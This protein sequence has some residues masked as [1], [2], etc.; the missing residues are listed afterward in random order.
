LVEYPK[1][2]E[3][4]PLITDLRAGGHNDDFLLSDVG[5]LYLRPDDQEPTGAALLVP[6]NG[7]IRAEV[8]EDAHINEEGE[9]KAFLGMTSQLGEV[10][11]WVGMEE[12]IERQIKQCEGCSGVGRGGEKAETDFEEGYT[13][14]T[15]WTGV[16]EDEKK[17]GA[18]AADMAMAMRR[19]EEDAKKRWEA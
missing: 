13:G 15:G 2:P 10:F 19:A 1:D 17:E 4:V 11:W 8:L 14:V 18:M 9:H 12:D 5:L 6:P 7:V 16:D 3:L